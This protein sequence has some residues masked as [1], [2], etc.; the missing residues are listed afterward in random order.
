VRTRT[1]MLCLSRVLP[2]YARKQ[3][4]RRVARCITN[5]TQHGRSRASDAAAA[6]RQ[7]QAAQRAPVAAPRQRH[8][9]GASNT[10]L[11]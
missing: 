3:H 6:C 10:S 1:G 4:A 7:L 5:A 9:R 11:S 8:N 2:R